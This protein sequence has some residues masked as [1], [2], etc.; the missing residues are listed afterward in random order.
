MGNKTAK[1]P[2]LIV[3]RDCVLCKVQKNILKK[4]GIQNEFKITEIH[5][6]TAQKIMQNAK[7]KG[8]DVQGTPTILCPE[9][10]CKLQGVQGPKM[11]KD[12]LKEYHKGSVSKS[13]SIQKKNMIKPNRIL[14]LGI[15]IGIIVLIVLAIVFY[16]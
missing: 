13:Q 15:S 1:K 2:I 16:L 10:N 9:M 7:L 14:F 12:F 4:E 6:K 8:N 11:L 5:S 3:N